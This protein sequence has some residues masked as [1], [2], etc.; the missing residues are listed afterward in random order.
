MFFAV[1]YFLL[2]L[3]LRLAPEG[4]DRDREAE[5]LVLRHQ[6]K[7][8][9]RKAGSPKLRRLDRVLLAAFSR[10]LP[11]D[12]WS[13]F[14]VSPQTLLRWHRDLVRRKWTYKQ[15]RVGRPR[16]DQEVQDLICRMAQANPRWGYMRIQG[17]CQKLGIRVAANTIKAILSRA[18][19][20]PA[21]RRGPSWSEFLRAQA[22]GILACDFFTVET[23]FLR[24]LYVL[25]F[26][27]VGTRRLHITAATRNPMDPSSPSRRETSSCQTSFKTSGS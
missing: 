6:L 25:F 13:A 11:R 10:L 15:K 27:E 22:Q 20:G 5:I 24:T 8:L 18:G 1:V 12:R 23:V 16:I 19:L 9:S 17:E 21:P 14:P 26:I 2:R 3:V 4:E 7:V